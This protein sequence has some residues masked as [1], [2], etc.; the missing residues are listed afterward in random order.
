MKRIVSYL[1]V[2]LIVFGILN[3]YSFVTAA[4]DTPYSGGSGTEDDPYLISTEKDII[5]LRGAMRTDPSLWYT[6]YY[7]KL[8]N[9]IET[10]YDLYVNSCTT[11]YNTSSFRQARENDEYF[12]NRLVPIYKDIDGEAGRHNMCDHAFD[13]IS[14]RNGYS[15]SY[16]YRYGGEGYP[17]VVNNI[18]Y[19]WNAAFTGVFDGNGYSIKLKKKGYFFG[20]IENEA[21]IKNLTIEGE[22]ASLAYCLDETSLIANCS[23]K[24][25]HDREVIANEYGLVVEDITE[26]GIAYTI[27]ENSEIYISALLGFGD[28]VVIPETI[29]G[30]PVVG[31]RD[32]AFT[33][34]KV[35]I[36]SLYIHKGIMDIET[37]AF[38]YNNSGACIGTIYYD[39][40]KSMLSKIFYSEINASS[41]ASRYNV[42]YS[43]NALIEGFALKNAEDTIT[44]M[45]GESFRPEYEVYPDNG[46]GWFTY[47]FENYSIVSEKKGLIKG[48]KAGETMVTV[49]SESGVEYSFK[50]KVIGMTGISVEKLPDKIYYGLRQTFDATGLEV[51][52]VYNDGTSA[53]CTD[54]TIS[55]Y[56][57]LKKGIQTITVTYEDCSATF[58]VFVSDATVGDVNMDGSISPIDSNYL[59]RIIVGNMS[60]EAYTDEYFVC[61]M[62]GDGDIN[63]IDSALLKK[64]FVE[65]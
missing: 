27:T 4:E 38:G 6:K 37:Y 59:K 24:N 3:S 13:I 32:K 12:L 58:D 47:S 39:G 29:D 40:T 9:D 62:N 8:T 19:Y 56:N 30:M 28:T 23:T 20:F 55:S 51:D 35:D 64:S 54:Y 18:S 7:Y 17:S 10:S 46:R 25:S 2:A 26:N 53:E 21:M 42:V 1:L 50:V 45:V 11:D 65:A 61:D 43:N 52:K 60:A 16:F 15:N 57:A 22:E 33:F 5:E 49:T 14:D 31:I 34:K 41:I 44:L 36:E 48:E 63:S